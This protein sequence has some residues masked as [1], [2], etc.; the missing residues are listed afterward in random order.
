MSAPNLT[1]E[2]KAALEDM[3]KEAGSLAKTIEAAVQE[4][5]KKSGK[6]LSPLVLF[7]AV[8]GLRDFAS[9]AWQDGGRPYSELVLSAELLIGMMNKNERSKHTRAKPL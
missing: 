9:Y 4:Y 2:A 1:L 3:A 6:R 8:Q 5:V 7:V